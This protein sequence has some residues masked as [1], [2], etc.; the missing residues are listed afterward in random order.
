MAQNSSTFL[1]LRNNMT[2]KITA[3]LDGETIH[4]HSDML[5]E[6]FIWQLRLG[7]YVDK[8]NICDGAHQFRKD[9]QGENSPILH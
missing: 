7:L 9:G 5:G 1:H 6:K 3:S 4:K 8:W 2:L